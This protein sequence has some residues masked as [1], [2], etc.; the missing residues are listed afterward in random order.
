[1]L[2]FGCPLRVGSHRLLMNI[3]APQKQTSMTRLNSIEIDAFVLTKRS[4]QHISPQFSG[5]PTYEDAE[6]GQSKCGFDSRCP[7]ILPLKMSFDRWNPLNVPRSCPGHVFCTGGVKPRCD[8]RCYLRRKENFACV[9]IF[10]R[11]SRR[12]TDDLNVTGI[13]REWTCNQTWF[14][15]HRS[16]VR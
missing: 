8:M 5:Y 16:S 11:G 12:K 15:L 4:D 13:R 10:Y 9:R 7:L 6:S 1:M 14:S 3:L 2:F